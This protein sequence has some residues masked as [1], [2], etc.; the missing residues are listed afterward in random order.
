[1]ADRHHRLAGM[2]FQH[3]PEGIGGSQ[4]KRLKRVT[5]GYAG[6]MRRAEP[7]IV[8]SLR[9]LLDL[10]MRLPAP[11]T[12]IEVEQLRERL[13]DQAVAI[14][15]GPRC[16]RGSTHRAGEHGIDPPFGRDP[17][18][19]SGRLSPAQLRQRDFLAA[20]KALGFDAFD[21]TVAHENEFHG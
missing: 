18:C 15:D 5:A 9:R 13:R 10:F 19:S 17:F 2:G 8:E 4:R 1:M 6:Q 3:E 20:P 7:Q 12:I 21:M 16:V 11:L 14:G